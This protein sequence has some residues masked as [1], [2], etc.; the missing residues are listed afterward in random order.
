MMIARDMIQL[1]IMELV[2]GKDPI[3]KALSG[4]KLTPV[5]PAP[6]RGEKKKNG[7]K[8]KPYLTISIT[9]REILAWVNDQEQEIW[10]DRVFGLKVKLIINRNKKNLY[11]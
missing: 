3:I 11:P 9:H 5:A 4:V 1:V 7:R 10:Y 8:H 2:T 6:K